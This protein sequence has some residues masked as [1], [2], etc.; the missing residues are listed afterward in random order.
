MS[1]LMCFILCSSVFTSIPSNEQLPTEVADSKSIVFDGWDHGSQEGSILSNSTATVGGGDGAATN[2]EFVCIIQENTFEIYCW[3]DNTHGQLGHPDLVSKARP[4]ISSSASATLPT[5][6]AIDA[7]GRHA[8]GIV[9]DATTNSPGNSDIFCW[10]ANDVGQFGHSGFTN[11]G[12]SYVPVAGALSWVND[13]FIDW[14]VY[15]ALAISSGGGSTCA[16]LVDNQLSKSLWCWGSILSS[17]TSIQPPDYQSTC[18]YQQI[19]DITSISS[20]VCAAEP[21]PWD[22]DGD[23]WAEHS[24]AY[25]YLQTYGQGDCNDYDQNTNPG[26]NEILGDLQDNDCDGSVDETL[27]H[28]PLPNQPTQVSV[29]LLYTSPSPRDATLSRMPSSA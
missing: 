16:I 4:T 14:S 22:A 18:P 3:G 8:C 21:N 24:G 20:T 9:T 11:T 28:I 12:P 15:S 5:A 13:G 10:G 23:G 2:E 27:R 26:Q 25:G 17:G 1:L 6:S 7:G 29:C 19:L